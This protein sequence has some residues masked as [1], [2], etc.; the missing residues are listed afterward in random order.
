MS[1]VGS[2]PLRR[3]VLGMTLICKFAQL[4]AGESRQFGG[5]GSAVEASGELRY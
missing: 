5:D 4:L 1:G 3:R 2:V